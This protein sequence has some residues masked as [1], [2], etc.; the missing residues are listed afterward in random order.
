MAFAQSFHG[1]PASANQTKNPYAGDSQAAAGKKL[2]A[3]NCS[4]CH[5]NNLQGMG[6]APAL[7]TAAV[8]HA[9]PGELFWFVTNGDL[10]KGMPSWPQLTSQQRWQIVTFLEFENRAK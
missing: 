2:Y 10:S 9:A 5:G 1:A 6:P 3:Q 7:T 4:Q 8:K